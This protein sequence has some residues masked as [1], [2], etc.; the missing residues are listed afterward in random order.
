MPAVP[1]SVPDQAIDAL[2]RQAGV[3]RVQ[4]LEE[5]L[6]VA[7][8]LVNQPLPAGRRVAVV[9]NAGGCGVLAADACESH[10]LE[11][12]ELSPE[13][14]RRLLG[15]VSGGASV[16][17]PVDLVAS[18]TAE[19]Y[20]SVLEILL[21][22]A[23]IDVLL[24]TFTPPV[25]VGADE[26]ARAV[27]QAAATTDKPV[28]ANF[29]ATEET[30]QALRA[31]PR[32]VPWFAYPE[33]A[34]RAVALVAQYGEWAARPEGT[35]PNFDNLDAVSARSIVAAALSAALTPA[36]PPGL[37]PTRIPG[38]CASSPTSVWLDTVAA[39]A[40]LEA[41]GIPILPCARAFTAAEAVQA[42]ARSD[43]RSPSSWT[44]LTLFTRAT[45]EAS[46]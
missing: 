25:L 13:T 34:A 23:D 18:A 14:Q 4:A 32:H 20:R 29:I 9:G 21:G 5:L 41:Y 17:N 46:A 45:S 19:E 27:A 37:R 26:I 6:D 16:G 40:L 3:I 42:R 43:T 33:S 24:V 38:R 11:V 12:P 2:F 8:L 1:R 30:L 28:L 39:F 35:V 7:D 44:P 31:G 36:L 10:G 15:V 22:E